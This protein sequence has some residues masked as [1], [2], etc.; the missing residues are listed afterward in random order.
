MKTIVA[1]TLVIA[2][3]AASVSLAATRSATLAISGMTCPTCPIT[4]RKALERVAG[5]SAVTTDFAKKTV[6]VSYDDTKARPEQLARATGAVGYPST[7]QAG[8]VQ[9][10]GD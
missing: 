8:P 10:H 5:V 3:A 7:V 9:P 1:M 6:T 4:V 2:S